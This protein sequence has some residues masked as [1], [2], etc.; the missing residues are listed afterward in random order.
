[1]PDPRCLVLLLLALCCH[2]PAVIALMRV[3]LIGVNSVLDQRQADAMTADALIAEARRRGRRRRL[4]RSAVITSSLVALAAGVVAGLH[5]AS[6]AGPGGT[7][8]AR[9]SGVAATS[10]PPEIVVVTGRARIEVVSSRTLRV[11]RTIA[12]NAAMFAGPETL[13]ASPSGVLFFDSARDYSERVMSVP[14]AGGPVRQVAYGRT[15]AISPD[16]T[17]LAY[18]AENKG[19]ATLGPAPTGIVVRDLAS[20]AQ[21][22]W[23][24]PPGSYIPAMTWS[25]D[26]RHLAVTTAAGPSPVT[27]VLDTQAPGRTLA[28][29][30]RI[31]LPPGV[32]WAGYLTASIG[33]GIVEAGAYPTQRTSLVEVD[34][35]TGQVTRRLTSL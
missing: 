17:L 10:M 26:G 1:M 24:L 32:S 6:R 5:G 9:R 22:T 23:A 30:R 15:P 27:V 13:T 21:R 7:V 33:V 3:C 31:P 25:P 4:A 29:A 18:V 34:V 11:M 2:R 14:L 35:R 20:G 16:G 19:S 12:T 28:A 8:P